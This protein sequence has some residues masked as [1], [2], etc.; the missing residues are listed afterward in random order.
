MN[1]ERI[2]SEQAVVGMISATDIFAKNKLLIEKNTE[3]TERSI[4]RLKLYGVRE[5]KVFASNEK[6]AYV[7]EEEE[8]IPQD[9]PVIEDN[10]SYHEKVRRTKEFICFQDSIVSYA[11]SLKN[12]L[13]TIIKDNEQLD[14]ERLVSEIEAILVESRNGLHVIDMLNCMRT[15]DDDTYIHSVNVALLC[16]IMGGWMRYSLSETRLLALSGLLHDIGKLMIPQELITKPSQLTP[17]EY[18]RVKE[19][20][21]KGYFILKHQDLDVRVK[22]AALMHHEKCDGSGYP[23]GLTR[24]QIEPFAKIVA[25]ADIYEAMTAKRVYRG[26][27]CPFEVI[28]IFEKEGLQKYDPVYLLTFLERVIEAY[29]NNWV[30]LSNE[31]K[32][33]IIMINK[34]D[35]AKPVV[36]TQNSDFI[37]LSKERDIDILAII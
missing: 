35:L 11:N 32:A 23:L 19:H 5:L 18:L 4:I 29:I 2:S 24:S 30:L 10:M 20:T 15:Y 13:D 3:L 17:E 9:E 7:Q 21:N 16:Y 1:I 37:D 14:T 28:A 8:H 34:Y 12:Y 26:R 33:E 36:R 25:I 27:I 31:E 22:R 6:N